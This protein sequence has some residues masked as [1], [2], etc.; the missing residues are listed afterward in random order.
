MSEPL[1]PVPAPLPL[2][3]TG[4]PP[5]SS[6]FDDDWYFD[7]RSGTPDPAWP[8]VIVWSV[9]IVALVAI[10]AGIVSGLT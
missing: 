6:R 5:G 3:P 9:L 1:P 4:P 10:G 7:N 8:V 2:P